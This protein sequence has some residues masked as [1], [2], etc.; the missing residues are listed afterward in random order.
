MN[1][2][3]RIHTTHVQ[4]AHFQLQILLVVI[5][6]VQDHTLRMQRRFLVSHARR[7][8]SLVLYDAELVR[9]RQYFDLFINFQL[10][11]DRYRRRE[12]ML[13]GD[14]QHSDQLFDCTCRWIIYS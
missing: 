11:F 13:T 5:P 10:S 2:R 9:P 1:W 6:A 3:A 8:F 14:L 4:Q 7:R 12:R